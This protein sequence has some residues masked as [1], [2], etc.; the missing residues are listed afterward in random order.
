VN[1]KQNETLLFT[2]FCSKSQH[3][4]NLSSPH[5]KRYGFRSLTINP[6]TELICPVRDNFSLPLARSQIC[7]KKQVACLALE[8]SLIRT[9]T[10]RNKHAF[11]NKNIESPLSSCRSNR[12]KTTR[13]PVQRRCSVPNPGAH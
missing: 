5:E 6:R 13:F 9:C 11:S 10:H 7:Y 1:D 4:T 12:C 8:T 3:F 2:L